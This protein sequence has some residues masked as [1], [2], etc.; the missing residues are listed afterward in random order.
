MRARE[1]IPTVREPHFP[2]SRRNLRQIPSDESVVSPDLCCAD[3]C[4]AS[5][6]GVMMTTAAA[7]AVVIQAVHLNPNSLLVVR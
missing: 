1:E 2:V 3:L 7:R 5:W 4:C 6:I